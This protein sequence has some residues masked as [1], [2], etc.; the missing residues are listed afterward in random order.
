MP[1]RQIVLLA[2]IP[3]LVFVPAIASAQ[4]KDSRE[5]LWAAVRNGDAVSA[6]ALLDQGADVNA[7][8]EIGVTALWI[9]ASKG[10]PEVVEV[11]LDRGADVNARDGIWYLTPLAL[12]LR[13]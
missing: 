8:S 1:L 7:K 13:G 5:A 11:L 4:K 3:V 12:A 6:K 10:K 9:A 2:A